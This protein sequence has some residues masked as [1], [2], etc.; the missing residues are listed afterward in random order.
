VSWNRNDVAL[1]WGRFVTNLVRTRVSYS[2]TPR[3][4]VQGLLQY[5]DRA[6][7]WS[8]NLRF[9]WLQSSNTGLFVVFNDVQDLDD[10]ST[11]RVGRSLVVKFSRLFD[12][13][14]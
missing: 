10:L 8:S 11:R 6:Q 3:V 2:F 5:N 14:Q 9:G 13:L 7:I 4:Y 12:L 1:P